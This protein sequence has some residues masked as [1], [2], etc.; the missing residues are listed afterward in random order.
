MAITKLVLDRQAAGRVFTFGSAAAS[1]DV[2]LAKG[3]GDGAETVLLTSEGSIDIKGDLKVTG[4]LSVNDGIN[5]NGQVVSNIA[6][7]SAGTDAANKDYVDSEIST[8]SGSFASSVVSIEADVAQLQSDLDA[9]ELDL[10][11]VSSSVVTL[12]SEMSQAQSD[13]D[14]AELNI[15]T[16]QSDLDVAEADIDSLEGRMTTAEGDIDSLEGRMTTAEGDI[17]SLESRMSTA[18]GNISTLQSEML[19]EQGNVDQ[20]Q[21]D[22]SQAQIDIDQLQADMLVAQSDIDQLQLDVDALEAATSSYALL[23]GGN[24]FTGNQSFANDVTITGNLIVNG[25]QTI[26][27]STQVDIGDNIIS[28]NGSGGAYA[29]IEVNDPTAPNLASGS[30]LWDSANDRWIAGPKGDEKEVLVA[31][32]GTAGQVLTMVSGSAVFAAPQ[33]ITVF[34][35]ASYVGDL[36]GSNKSFTVTTS[37]NLVE[38]SEQVILNGIILMPGAG[39]DYTFASGVMQFNAAFPAPQADDNLQ[40]FATF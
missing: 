8:F 14:A 21:S 1:A 18:E 11:N 9:A 25:T 38:G 29:G 17:D 39:N 26:V 31:D 24:S 35:R 19:V 20:L 40:I 2:N 28:L 15:F 32:L 22:M 34:K 10:F 33:I 6:G 3:S 23:D 30:L 37:A 7:P 13:I 5:A 16:L 4:S 27:N 12:K 36:D